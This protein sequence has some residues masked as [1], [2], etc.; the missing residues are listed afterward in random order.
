MSAII[1]ASRS[2]GDITEIVQAIGTGHDIV[3][4]A[5]A[6]GLAWL[7]GLADL[8]IL[9]SNL[10]DAGGMDVLSDV[11][12]GRSLP[13]LMLAPLNDPECAAQ[14]MRS[15]A[16]NY[17]VKVPGY[18]KLL[19]HAVQEALARFHERT[20][21]PRTASTT[22][23]TP[24]RMQGLPVEGANPP[25]AVSLHPSAPAARRDSGLLTEILSLTLEGEINLP[26]YPKA[27]ADLRSLVEAQASLPV[28]ANALEQDVAIACK[29][30][31]VSNLPYYRTEKENSTVIAAIGRLGLTE[32]CNIAELLFNRSLYTTRIPNLQLLLPS[33]WTHAVASAYA[34]QLTARQLGISDA[35]PVFTMGLLHDIGKLLLFQ[36]IGEMQLRGLAKGMD[37]LDIMEFAHAHHCRFGA[38]I[39]TRWKLPAAIA[40]VALWHESVL[41]AKTITQDLLIVQFADAVAAFMGH[42]LSATVTTNA[43]DNAFA[44]MAK[45]NGSAR[46]LELSP[47]QIAAIKTELGEIMTGRDFTF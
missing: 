11:A 28:I 22:A 25:E 14:A 32:T 45:L 18:E 24:A 40:D 44:R 39:L 29:L 4:T 10:T 33:L 37:F 13:T 42:S 43:G 6:T 31:G 35:G 2:Q 26:C 23:A 41:E 38:E 1:I 16:F 17:I 20:G 19:S 12:A 34:A 8:L 36:V 21:K 47:A 30:I 5:S 3:T 15:G 46:L 27:V 9:D 7:L